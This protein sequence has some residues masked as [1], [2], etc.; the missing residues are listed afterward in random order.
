MLAANNNHGARRCV[1][2]VVNR[3]GVEP[4]PE[5]M[6]SV[7]SQ[8]D[9]FCLQL[10]RE[11]RDLLRRTTQAD[12]ETSACFRTKLALGESAQFCRAGLKLLP[13]LGGGIER[14]ERARSL[15]HVQQS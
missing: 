15:D 8:D 5:T 7:T 4:S 11:V 14:P 3:V 1:R 12:H 9:Q 10:S 2:D 13:L 6:M